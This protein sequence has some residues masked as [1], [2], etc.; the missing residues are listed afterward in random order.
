MDRRKIEYITAS[1]AVSLLFVMTLGAILAIANT[2]FNWDIFPPNIEK[3]L[4]FLLASC[5]AIIISSVL[6]NVMIN[7]S[8]IASN[9]ERFL[10]HETYKNW[11]N[12]S[13]ERS[14]KI[15]ASQ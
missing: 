13:H 9:S 14:D 12:V 7:L 2:M 8:I 4:W 11:S 10:N 3:V 5:L 6:V 1:L 15:T